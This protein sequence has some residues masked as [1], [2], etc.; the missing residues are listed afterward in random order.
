MTIWLRMAQMRERYRNVSKETIKRHFGAHAQYPLRNGI[1]HWNRDKLDQLDR[2]A[3]I[4][5]C[6]KEA[7]RAARL[8]RRTKKTSNN[9]AE[10]AA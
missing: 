5:G 4:E 6:G 7:S 10:R 2:Q 9:E 8:P 1:P 3:M